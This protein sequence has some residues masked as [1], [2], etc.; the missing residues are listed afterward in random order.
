ME[1]LYWNEHQIIPTLQQI[2]ERV[3]PYAEKGEVAAYIPEL[4]KSNPRDLGVSVTFLNGATYSVG[5]SAKR[6]TLQSI[7]KLFSLLI[8]LMDRGPDEVFAVVGKEP[9]GDP[10]NSIVKLETM[11]PHK[12]LN[13]MINAGAI[14]VSSLIKGRDVQER[15]DKVLDLLKQM[16]GNHTLGVNQHVYKSERAT[17]DRN[18][19][20]AYFMKDSGIIEG[21]VEEVLDLYFLHCSI[22]AT[23]EDVSAIAVVLANNGIHPQTK[24]QLVPPEYAR[25]CKSFM[26]TCGMYNASGAFAIDAGIP[27]KSGVGGG[28]LASVPNK[29]GIGVYGPALNDKGNSLAGV[30]FLEEL[31]KEWNLSIF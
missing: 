9:T 10:F 21:D 27:A 28:I 8:A 16:S 3:S 4:S 15:L 31:S 30:L 25:I 11:T 19:A 14:A 22:E 29:M 13:P 7:S 5:D 2:R 23:T 24:Q 20:L 17:A 26:V 6:F 18:R 12:P 1:G